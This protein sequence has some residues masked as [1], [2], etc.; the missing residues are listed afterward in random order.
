MEN[1]KHYSRAFTA[2]L[3]EEL[4]AIV[5]ELERRYPDEPN[6]LAVG[7]MMAITF[8]TM[9]KD[10]LGDE[11]FYKD[12][13]DLPDTKEALLELLNELSNKMDCVSIRFDFDNMK[14]E[15]EAAE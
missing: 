9:I 1:M 6:P 2:G 13:N 7:V 4:D 15:I 11:L 14:R 10:D 12:L 5:E 8:M 3:R